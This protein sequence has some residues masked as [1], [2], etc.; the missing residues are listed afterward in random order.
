[1]A[2]GRDRIVA[3]IVALVGSRGYRQTSLEEVLAAAAVGNEEE[4]A[5]HF[6]SK[7]QCFV[8]V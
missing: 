5:R 8:A 2:D 6:A 3:A 7:Q 4:F 1:M